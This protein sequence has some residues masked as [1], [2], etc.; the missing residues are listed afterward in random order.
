VATL[1]IDG[2]TLAYRA[3]LGA[4][5]IVEDFDGDVVQRIA[6]LD[7]ARS[8]VDAEIENICDHLGV[9]TYKLALTGPTNFRKALLPTYKSKRGP[10]PMALNGVRKHL[11][12]NRAAVIKDG[13]EADD[14]VGIWATHPTLIK[15][16]KI[17]VSIDKD[18]RSIPGKLWNTNREA[19]VETITLNQADY[20]HMRQTLTGDTTDGYVGCPK[21][22]PITA[23][24]MLI[25]EGVPAHRV[26]K[27]EI[28][29][30]AFEKAGLT[31]DD[32]LVQAR[33][34]RILR[35]TDYDFKKK[36]PILWTPAT[37]GTP[38]AKASSSS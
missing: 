37:S 27:W 16:E 22:G 5:K 1:L 17:V 36:E 18:L 6:D 8:T 20:W 2:D 19:P 28:V 23:D 3:A 12:E 30:A 7:E 10:K 35:S 38:S 26:P 21:V 13:L 14:V 15:G 29:L 34:A 11:V 25:P 32:A 33:V 9:K 4:E 24:R 31:E